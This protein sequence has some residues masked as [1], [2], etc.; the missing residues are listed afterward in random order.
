MEAEMAK[1]MDIR[2]A[3]SSRVKNQCANVIEFSLPRSSIRFPARQ[4][5]YKYKGVIFF[6]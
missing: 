2:K 3:D 6:G 1:V 5:V 4:I